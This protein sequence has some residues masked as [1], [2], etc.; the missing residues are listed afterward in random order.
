MT[1]E[2]PP[3]LARHRE[4]FQLLHDAKPQDPAGI[5]GLFLVAELE[6]LHR[7]RTLNLKE[8]R[9]MAVAEALLQTKGRITSAARMLGVSRNTIYL[10]LEKHNRAKGIVAKRKTH[11]LPGNQPVN[12]PAERRQ[13][14]DN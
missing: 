5:R 6:D 13:C 3:H 11:G 2:L 4:F 14:P 10:I 1:P 12:Q 8:V 7:R 9:E